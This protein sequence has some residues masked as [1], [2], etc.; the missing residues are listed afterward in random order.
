MDR[1][2]EREAKDLNQPPAFLSPEHINY[3]EGVTMRTEQLKI[4]E[5]EEEDLVSVSNQSEN[6]QI[7]GAGTKKSERYH[8]QPKATKTAMNQHFRNLK[9]VMQSPGS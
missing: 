2:D 6:G 5:D 1:S 4:T 3:H 8:N 7:S 9:D